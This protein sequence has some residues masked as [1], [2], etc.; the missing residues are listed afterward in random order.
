MDF[1]KLLRQGSSQAMLHV[2]VLGA[3]RHVTS[4]AAVGDT[5]HCACLPAC[6]LD[7]GQQP[8][9]PHTHAHTQN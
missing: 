6:P 2:E 3:Q 4:A 5:E 7:A 8:P 1:V 9:N